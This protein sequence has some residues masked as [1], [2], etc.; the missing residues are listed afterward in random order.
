MTQQSLQ[1][2]HK[3]QNTPQQFENIQEKAHIWAP[4]KDWVFYPKA[5]LNAE[6]CYSYVLWTQDP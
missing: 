6:K 1:T 3:N 4:E 5:N 2:A